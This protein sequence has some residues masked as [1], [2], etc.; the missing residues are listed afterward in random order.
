MDAFDPP[1]ELLKW[2]S[3]DSGSKALIVEGDAG[4]GK[5]EMCI[6]ALHQLAGSVHFLSKLDQLKKIHIAAGQALLVDDLSLAAT[7][8]DDTK[9][10]LDVRK[11]RDVSNR[12]LDGHI[13]A[14]TIR[15]F[16]SNHSRATFFCTEY[17]SNPVHKKAIDRRHTWITVDR[18]VRRLTGS[19]A[20]VTP[21]EPTHE[22]A[23]AENV[24]DV[25]SAD[26]AFANE[27]F[28]D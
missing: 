22:A 21:A 4:L 14:Q 6:A 16:C 12:H 9:A 26:E 8:A 13:P 20:S 24:P 19:Q 3:E 2:M 25:C 10:W 28:Q 18:D 15:A 11:P 7:T 27:T 5:T 17:H 1:P 23:V